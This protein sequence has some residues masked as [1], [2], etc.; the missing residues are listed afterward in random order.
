MPFPVIKHNSIFAS[1][2]LY[3][4]SSMVILIS[5]VC[6]CLIVLFF[7]VSIAFSIYAYLFSL[8]DKIFN[9]VIVNS[10]PVTIHRLLSSTMLDTTNSRTFYARVRIGEGKGSKLETGVGFRRWYRS[11]AVSPQV[12]EAI[13]LTEG[14]HY[15]PPGPRLAP[16][17]PSITAHCPIL[18]YTACCADRGTCVQTTCPGSAEAGIRTRDLLIESPAYNHS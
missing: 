4:P 6:C 9:K 8:W 2:R 5:N 16:Q 7:C 3:I 14:C 17:P 10:N 1:N 11:F 12:T 13:N 15:F 18:N